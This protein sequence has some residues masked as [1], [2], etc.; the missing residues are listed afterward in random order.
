MVTPHVLI[1]VDL[2]QRF[3]DE[4]ST[5]NSISS[6]YRAGD[7]APTLRQGLESKVV[8][9]LEKLFEGVATALPAA[10]VGSVREFFSPLAGTAE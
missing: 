4:A 3:A 8:V 7:C 9:F 10:P 5:F 2:Y 6:N 1:E